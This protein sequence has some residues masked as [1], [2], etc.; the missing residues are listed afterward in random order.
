MHI[1]SLCSNTN[2]YL[3]KFLPG[4][5]L[6]TF[7]PGLPKAGGFTI[8]STPYEARPG[9][10]SPPYLELAIQKSSNPPAQWLSR[11]EA[12]I[13]GS[14]LMV[15]TGGSFTWPPPGL[16]AEKIERLVLVAGGVGINPLISIFSYLIRSGTRPKEIHFLYG[17]KALSSDPDP[18]TILFL[19]RLM[20]LVAA[21]DQPT[22]ITL[23]LFLTDLGQGDQGIIEH[24]KLPNR[25]FGRR[26]S[27]KD[28]VGAIDGWKK[29]TEGGEGRYR[30]VCYVCGPQKM[31]DE[32][33]GFLQ[34]QEGMGPERVLCEKWW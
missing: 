25:T 2:V 11:P 5:W 34:R 24:G 9:Q 7:I 10:D 3:V 21:I 23:S 14:R 4:Q 20:D 8:T 27:E 15:R 16:Y 18:Q 13:L 19:P 28:L 33:V 32:I 6:D 1:V 17:T 30:T 29:G 26:I 31:T 22:T 12:E